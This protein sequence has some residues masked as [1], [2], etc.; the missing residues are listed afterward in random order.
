[1]KTIDLTIGNVQRV[2]LALALPLVGSSLLQF[3]YSL[4][5]MFWVGALGSDAVA[6]IGAASFY[7]MLGQAI[8]SLIV[9]GAG[10]KVSQAV[11]RRDLNSVQRY[12]RAGRRLNLTLGLSY[13]SLLIV[14][15]HT[16]IGFL[17]MGAPL[18]SSLRMNICSSAR[19]CSFSHSLICCLLVYSV[20][21]AIRQQRCESMRQAS[22]SIWFSPRF[23]F[24]HSNSVWSG[25]LLQ[26]LS[27]TS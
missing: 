25:L 11:G 21:M 18:W 20:H 19:R 23:S 16:F 8:Q 2:I 27:P 14:L 5:D 12:V 3:S 4:V 6:S 1:M 15:G 10:I 24:I 13:A 22:F 17:N 26:H 7:I 9:V